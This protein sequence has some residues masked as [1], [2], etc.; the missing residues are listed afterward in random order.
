MALAKTHAAAAVAD[1]DTADHF[2][3]KYVHEGGTGVDVIWVDEISMLDI[4]LLCDLSH[5]TFRDPSPQWILSGDF[6][7]YEPFFN[8]F[9]GKPFLKSFEHSTLLRILAGRNRL[10]LTECKRSDGPLFGF[11]SSLIKG[12]SRFERPLAEVVAEA[13]E[14]YHPT[15]ARGFIPGTSLAHT[16]LVISH[17]LRV[18]LNAKC[19]VADAQ[20]RSGVEQYTLLDF[21]SDEEIAKQSAS[22]NQPQDAFFWPGMVVEARCS[23]RKLK[24]ALPYEILAFEG[25]S[26]RLRL[27]INPSDE[28][29]DSVAATEVTLCRRKFFTS[30][31]L[32]YARTYASIQGLT[33]TGLLALHDTQHPHFDMKKLFVGASRAVA[34]DLLIVH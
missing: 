6:N 29:D 9:R 23:G 22:T 3:W 14:I 31:R 10:T 34:S 18:E 1:G 17:K 30:M 19:N 33:I 32:R 7:Q 25:D 11:Y 8:A 5:L 13:R 26:V 21:F 27:A 20:G 12:G 28:D 24:N 15:K 2:A 16:N 4:E